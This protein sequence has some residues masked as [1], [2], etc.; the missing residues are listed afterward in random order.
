MTTRREKGSRGGKTTNGHGKPNG[1]TNPREVPKGDF[2][3][4]GFEPA[5][6]KAGD[7]T[8]V[9]YFLTGDK[10]GITPYVKAAKKSLQDGFRTVLVA[11]DGMVFEGS[12]AKLVGRIAGDQ[13]EKACEWARSDVLRDHHKQY[14][15]N[16]GG[17]PRDRER[18]INR[19]KKAREDILEVRRKEAQ[20]VAELELASVELVER[21]GKQPIDIDGV[22]FDPCFN[23]EKVFWKARSGGV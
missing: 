23:R 11:N 6:Q 3:P 12:G 2:L 8:L 10:R 20:A 5:K 22:T 7:S 13:F 14:L 18:V 4:P 19:Y 9:T 15:I 17:R 16:G 21:F 1:P